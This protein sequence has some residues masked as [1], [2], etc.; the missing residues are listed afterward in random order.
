MDE[1]HIVAIDPI[2]RHEQPARQSLLDVAARVS[3]GRIATLHGV[4]RAVRMRLNQQLIP[5]PEPRS[6]SGS[7]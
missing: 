1:R 3:Q 7:P 5:R 4:T 6:M 2:A